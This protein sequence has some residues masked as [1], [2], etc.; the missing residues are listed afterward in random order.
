MLIPFLRAF[1][2]DDDTN[3]LERPASARDDEDEVRFGFL[4]R[5]SRLVP[6]AAPAWFGLPAD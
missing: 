4:R 3:S 1:P 2:I 6:N 5:R